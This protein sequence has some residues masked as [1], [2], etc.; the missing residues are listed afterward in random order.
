MYAHYNP[1]P[2]GKRTGDCVIRMLTKIFNLTWDE[3]YLKLSTV[4]L[5]EYEMPSDNTIWELYLKEHGFSKRLL[6][7]NCPRCMSVYEFC[8]RFPVG[9]F[10]VCTGSHVVA[11]IDG[12]YFDAWDSGDEVVSYF[13]LLR[14]ELA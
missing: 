4:V 3:A 1:N 11:V 12:L 8:E 14:K 2:L 13:F 9:T 7:T 6:P 10:V 5:R